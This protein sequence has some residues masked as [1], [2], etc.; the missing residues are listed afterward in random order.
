VESLLPSKR[1]G[2]SATPA[3]LTTGEILLTAHDLHEGPWGT[4]ISSTKCYLRDTSVT[5]R[6]F[7]SSAAP[8]V[9][10]EL[11]PGD[12]SVLSATGFLARNYNQFNRN[13]WLDC[14]VEHTSEA[15]FGLTM[16]C[17]R[18]G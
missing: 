11:D 15:F 18:Y 3:E 2:R 5:P 9:G 7:Q 17:C 10:D 14:T 13:M 1:C 16:N 12:E 8:R 4:V 6:L